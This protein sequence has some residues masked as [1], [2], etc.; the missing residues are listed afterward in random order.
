MPAL[1]K[2]IVKHMA[3]T[4]FSEE[5]QKLLSGMTPV[6]LKLFLEKLLIKQPSLTDDLAIFL[7]GQALTPVTMEDYAAQFRI[8]LDRLDLTALL[9][10]WHQEGEDYYEGD[11]ND[12]DFPSTVSLSDVV[13]ELIEQ[14]E[15]Y[16]DNQNHGEALKI[17]QALFEA[18]CQKQESLEGDDAELLDVFV[19]ET[20]KVVDRY[21]QTGIKTNSV[22]LKQIAVSFLCSL[23]D[24]PR[25]SVN[26]EQVVAGLRQ[27]ITTEVDSAYA[28][29]CLKSVREKNELSVAESSLLAFLYSVSHQWPLF[30][31]ISRANVGN[32]PGIALDLLRFFH[33]NDR[34]S[35]VVTVSDDVLGALMKKD[36]GHDKRIEIQIRQFLKSAYSAVKDSSRIKPNLERL[37]L[38]T[39]LL[40]DYKELIERYE[41][42]SQKESFWK[43]MKE[44]FKKES[45]VKTIFNVFRFENQKDEVLDLVRAYPESDSFPD[46]IDFVKDVYPKESFDQYQKKING[47][48]REAKVEHYAPAAYHLTRMSTIGCEADFLAYVAWI[49]TTYQR[50]RRLIEELQKHHL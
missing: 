13:D 17:Y 15:T 1:L 22:P 20:E 40:S 31:N 43:M 39:G 6:Q 49:K 10:L 16:E 26:D 37:F 9:E 4:L 46:M 33:K 5:T 50:R 12:R 36:Q 18:L 2:N 45:D 27:I 34:M 23:F 28:L 35:D 24:H 19:Q 3:D 44:H 11:W 47:L 38:L 21:I 8:K 32:N 48:L 14:A 7:Q 41:H 29:D 25:A 30:E 42:T